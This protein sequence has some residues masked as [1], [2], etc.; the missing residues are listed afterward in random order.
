MSDYRI[1]SDTLGNVKVPKNVLWGAQ[2]ERSRH[3]FPVGPKMPVLVIRALINIKASAAEVSVQQKTIEKQKG[4]LIE[5]SAARLLELS[6]EQLMQNFPLHIYQTGSGTQ[7]NMNVNEVIAHVAKQIDPNTEI[8]PNDDVNHS[9]SSN[10][11]FP[12]AMNIASLVAINQLLPELQHL[13]KVMQR[14]QKKYW[15]VVKIGRTHL[16]DATPMTFGQEV[17]GW[18]ST[19]QHDL[20]F[21]ADNSK[22][23]LGLP[24]GGTAVGTGLN[25]AQNFDVE[26][27]K[28]LGEK[29]HEPFEVENKFYGLASHSALTMTHGAVRTLATD[30]MKIA[31]DIKFLASGPRAGYGEITIPANE[32]GSSIMPGKV[33]PTQGEAMDMVV[34]RIMGNDTTIEMANTQGNF[35]MNV[36]KPII[37]ECFLDSVQSLTG[38]LSHFTDL[39]VDGIEVNQDRMEELVHNSLMTVTALSPHIGY[40]RAAEIAQA[41]LNGKTDLRQAA[42]ES[43]YVTGSDFDKWVKPLEM[44]NH[45]RKQ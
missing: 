16:Q 42:V 19:I 33:N 37:I 6:D 28:N 10:D 3:N 29:Y 1:E 35:E 34:A 31:N 43:G 5:E 23:L 30:L 11:T 25:T 20:Q 32:P 27:V 24:I 41:A 18:A 36:Y 12:T 9:Q 45:N 13:I 4:A 15:D 22:S 14:L 44:T 39:M 2:T 38:I 26:M 17:S 40:H 8:L 7:T 21:V